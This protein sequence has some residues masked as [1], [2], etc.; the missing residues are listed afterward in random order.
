MGPDSC[1]ASAPGNA[2]R[3]LLYRAMADA[4]SCNIGNGVERSGRQITGDHPKF[5]Y[6]RHS[7]LLTSHLFYDKL[8]SACV[9]SGKDARNALA[10]LPYPYA[11]L[12][13]VVSFFR[14]IRLCKPINEFS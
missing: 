2:L 9:Y 7:L 10:Y 11:C 4:H 14:Y 12:I 6:A 1:D 8:G 5:S 3:I 13:V